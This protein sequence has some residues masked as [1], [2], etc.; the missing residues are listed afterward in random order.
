MTSKKL[1]K[2][3][4]EVAL[5]LIGTALVLTI[6]FV[7]EVQRE[8]VKDLRDRVGEAR[9]ITAI[10][11]DIRAFR[12][13]LSWANAEASESHTHASIDQATWQAF[14]SEINKREVANISAAG[15][16]SNLSLLV[17]SL[18]KRGDFEKRIEDLQSKEREIRREDE[19]LKG[20]VYAGEIKSAHK[21]ETKDSSE[22]SISE[23]IQYVA[24]ENKKIGDAWQKYMFET[25]QLGI[26]VVNA[27]NASAEQ[28]QNTYER[29]T[30]WSYVLIP[31]GFILGAVGKL[32]GIESDDVTE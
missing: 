1:R 32:L 23:Q 9:M 12:T 10:R 26:E 17:F 24:N 4:A 31:T 21:R 13:A 20:Q 3:V 7:H 5:V 15:E 30:F 2:K 6:F 22:K 18:D 11:D 29:L 28:S 8:K 19:L 25:R 16:L 27:A 14:N